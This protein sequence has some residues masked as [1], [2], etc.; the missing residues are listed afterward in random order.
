MP[1]FVMSTKNA[2]IHSCHQQVLRLNHWTFPN[3]ATNRN[4]ENSLPM[5]W[6]FFS[7]LWKCKQTSCV[8]DE[9]NCNNA[10]MW[11]KRVQVCQ[12]RLDGHLSNIIC[13]YSILKS[14]SQFK[15]NIRFI[16]ITKWR[17]VLRNLLYTFKLLTKF[18]PFY[19]RN[20]CIYIRFLVS[21]LSLL[22]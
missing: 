10:K 1:V 19:E 22:I 20:L 21:L 14:S 15:Q 2:D 16:K 3:R 8:Q 12:Q 9:L 6:E 4:C 17:P 7:N 5:W 18:Q 11:S 13:L